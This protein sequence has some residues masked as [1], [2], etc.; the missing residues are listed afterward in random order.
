MKTILIK[1]K[2]RK[3]NCQTQN[4]MIKISKWNDNFMS[5]QNDKK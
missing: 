2:K 3:N 1:T 5:K 4:K